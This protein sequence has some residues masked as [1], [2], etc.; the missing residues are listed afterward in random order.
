MVRSKQIAV[1]VADVVTREHGETFADQWFRL[2]MISGAL[3]EACA[4]T[5]IMEWPDD[6]EEL[7]GIF[8]DL[9]GEIVRRVADQLRSTIAETFIRLA[10]ETLA[11]ERRQ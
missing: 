5:E 8:H 2:S 7:Q 10:N 3:T 9:E 4:K 11:P 6:D 1:A